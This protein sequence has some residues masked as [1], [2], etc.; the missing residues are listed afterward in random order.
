MTSATPD[1]SGFPAT[2]TIALS[3]PNTY[4]LR[5]W[6][7]GACTQLPRMLFLSCRHSAVDIQL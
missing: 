3:D 1:A 6:R 5:T 7:C 4:G 2:L